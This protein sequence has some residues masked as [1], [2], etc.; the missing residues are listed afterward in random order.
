MIE[1]VIVVQQLLSKQ[2]REV[3]MRESLNCAY[4]LARIGVQHLFKQVL[5][6]IE[7]SVLRPLSVFFE[8]EGHSSV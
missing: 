3:I 6:K 2:V 5:E 7:F 8:L 1:N 4:S